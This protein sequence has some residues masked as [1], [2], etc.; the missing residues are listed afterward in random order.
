MYEQAAEGLQKETIKTLWDKEW[1][2]VVANKQSI[3]TGLAQLHQAKVMDQPS[4]G[5]VFYC[6]KSSPT[7]YFQVS[8]ADKNIGEE[9][10]RLQYALL[11]LAKCD[12]D[13]VECKKLAETNLEQAKKDNDFIYHEKVPDVNTLAV[14]EKAVV[15]KPTTIPDKFLPQETGLFEEM[16]G[17]DKIPPK[18][19]CVVS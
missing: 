14:I 3:Y 18:Q 6:I 7:T 10:A 17:W 5:V 13:L 4:L 11:F 12:D 15:A 19:E 8:K 2:S 16:P 9:I 1:I